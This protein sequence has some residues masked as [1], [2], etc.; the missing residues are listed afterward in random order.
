MI[1]SQFAEFIRSKYNFMHDLFQSS[2]LLHK[3]QRST[4]FK[5]L[6][7]KDEKFLMKMSDQTDHFIKN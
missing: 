6:N 5:L 1:K 3:L 2:I 4:S 7:M